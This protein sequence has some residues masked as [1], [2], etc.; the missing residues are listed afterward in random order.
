M[1]RGHGENFLC[2]PIQE[3]SYVLPDPEK[4]TWMLQFFQRKAPSQ[5]PLVKVICLVRLPLGM[6]RKSS[7]RLQPHGGLP[8][9]LHI[10]IS[11]GRVDISVVA[12][13]NG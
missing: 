3:E 6:Y 12:S 10:Y 2:F 7:V 5:N 8:A 11:S 9:R 13:W 4:E 1:F